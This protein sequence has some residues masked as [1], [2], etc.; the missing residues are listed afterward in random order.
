M[1]QVWFSLLG[2]NASATARVMSRF[3]LVWF[4]KAYVLAKVRVISRFGLLC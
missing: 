2:L 4:V 3:G 1:P